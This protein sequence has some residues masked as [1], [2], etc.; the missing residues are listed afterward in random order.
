MFWK[1]PVSSFSP[2]SLI[3]AGDLAGGPLSPARHLSATPVKANGNA[4]GVDQAGPASFMSPVRGPSAFT[5]FNSP[6]RS[7]LMPPLLSAF[8]R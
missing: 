5:A 2:L 6:Q 3:S 1:N 4:T 7:R 8:A